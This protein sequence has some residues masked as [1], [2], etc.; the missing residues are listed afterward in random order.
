MA[1]MKYTAKDSV[2]S[3]IFRQPENMWKLYRTLRPEDTET[4]E[5]DC[6]LVTLEHVLTNGMINDLGFRVGNKL[7]VLMEAQ[8]RFTVNIVLRV[9]LYLAETYKE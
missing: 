2:F 7:I 9:L 6:K 8:T 3:F 1:E 4:K 5:A